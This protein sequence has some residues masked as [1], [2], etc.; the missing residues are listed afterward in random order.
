MKSF[1]ERNSS[2]SKH[3]SHNH[4]HRSCKKQKTIRAVDFYNFFQQYL[5]HVG[6]RLQESPFP[7]TVRSETSL[8]E[9]SYFA[10]GINKNQ[11]NYRISSQQSNTN[12]NKFNQ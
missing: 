9:C 12:Q 11:C 3:G 6:N 4:K 8:K 2:K 1:S 7:N 5:N 10:F